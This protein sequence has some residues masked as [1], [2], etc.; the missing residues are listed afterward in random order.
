MDEGYPANLGALLARL[1]VPR[2]SGPA[3][4][5]FACGTPNQGRIVSLC[6]ATGVPMWLADL[7]GIDATVTCRVCA[8]VTI[9]PLMRLPPPPADDRTRWN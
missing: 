9:V 2:E 3:L 4:D 6:S 8:G 1:H 7:L 5:C